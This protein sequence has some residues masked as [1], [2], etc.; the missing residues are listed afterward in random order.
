[1]EGLVFL[2]TKSKKIK[3]LTATHVEDRAKTT[4]LEV[5]SRVFDMYE[6]RGFYIRSLIAD[7]EF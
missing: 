4:Q 3:L 7:I 6:N 2:H 1:M 5:L